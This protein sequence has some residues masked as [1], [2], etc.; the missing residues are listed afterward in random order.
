[1]RLGEARLTSPLDGVVSVRAA[2]AGE[3][4]GA[5]QAVVT[6]VDPDD[7]WVRVDVEEGQ[8]GRLRL[9]DRLPVR[10]ASG[11]VREGT[12]TYRGV[13]AAF[14]TARDLP[15]PRRDLRTFEVRLRVDNRDRRLAPGVSATVLVAAE[16]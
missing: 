6:L 13:D 8:V 2:R 4:V 16:G 7:L 3:I 5:G 15:G 12:V 11:E 1:M 10:L 9:G 14:A